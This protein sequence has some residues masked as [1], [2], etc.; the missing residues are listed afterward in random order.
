M[1][2]SMTEKEKEK[3][4]Y[5]QIYP[6]CA[7]RFKYL[8]LFDIALDS[9]N[10][11]QS[12]FA[13]PK[14]LEKIS[15]LIKFENGIFVNKYELGDV[16]GD[17]L[18]ALRMKY[19]DLQ[20]HS[21][22]PAD[23]TEVYQYP[24][25]LSMLGQFSTMTFDKLYGEGK[26]KHFIFSPGNKMAEV[27]N[28]DFEKLF[29]VFGKII[30]NI[31]Y[32]TVIKAI[33]TE[34]ETSGINL[35]FASEL[36]LFP[37]DD[38]SSMFTKRIGEHAK[39]G[40]I[41]GANVSKK[42]Q[43][44]QK[45]LHDCNKHVVMAK[46]MIDKLQ[47]YKIHK[48]QTEKEKIL[49]KPQPAIVQNASIKSINKNFNDDFNYKLKVYQEIVD[50]INLNFFEGFLNYNKNP[51]LHSIENRNRV[52]FGFG[53]YIIKKIF[54]NKKEVST[55]ATYAKLY[56]NKATRKIT[57]K[58]KTLEPEVA[59][60]NKNAKLLT[61]LDITAANYKNEIYSF[62]DFNINDEG[63]VIDSKEIKDSKIAIAK[64]N[65]LEQKKLNEI[66]LE[67]N[68][69]K[70]ADLIKK[71]SNIENAKKFLLECFKYDNIDEK[72]MKFKFSEDQYSYEPL[73]KLYEKI[74]KKKNRK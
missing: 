4:K 47:T 14:E 69:E 35:D 1:S 20:D 40:K 54:K 18:K 36:F 42:L 22:T 68:K 66:E 31:E 73:K 55:L 5:L 6:N 21:I 67:N 19:K 10:G 27:E 72:T 62:L 34:T 57:S 41:G 8:S 39:K 29:D 44:L 74:L 7:T 59:K 17:I 2:T 51:V 26:F 15:K 45:E 60:Q 43:Q 37:E 53:I 58:N 16:G 13:S 56:F 71:T 3:E 38:E 28:I 49:K 63:K 50:F 64:Y 23:F 11:N 24:V 32:L 65:F 70:L 61:E 33:K 25:N 46:Q 52:I 48:I 30:P 9:Q 12:P